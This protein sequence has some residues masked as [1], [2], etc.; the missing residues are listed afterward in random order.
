M[1]ERVGEREQRAGGN[2]GGMRVEDREM[3]NRPRKS[4]LLL[5]RYVSFGLKLNFL[6][7]ENTTD[8]E[9]SERHF[10][11]THLRGCAAGQC[12]GVLGTDFLS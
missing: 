2:N 7:D 11:R 6:V 9:V 10:S 3:R 8:E 12:G 1:H 5:R 4:S